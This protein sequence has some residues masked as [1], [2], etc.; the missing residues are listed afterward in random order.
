MRAFI[1]SLDAFVA[2]TLALVAIYSLIFFSSVP[3]AYYFLLTQGHYLSRDTLLSLSLTACTSDYGSCISPG[4]S[5]LDNIVA[6]AKP[7][8]VFNQKDLVKSTVGRMIPQQ[9]GYTLEISGNGGGSWDLVYDTSSSGDPQH[10]TGKNRRFTVASQIITFDYS[11]QVNKLK[12][13]P[14]VYASCQGNGQLEGGTLAG[15]A[16]GSGTNTAPSSG[17]ITCGEI[18][19]TNS[20]GTITNK[21]R[22]NINPKDIPKDNG[23]GDIVPS[24]EVNLVRL[25]V[26]I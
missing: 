20:D 24:T 8:W 23:G 2:F 5:I 18:P 13:S 22:G 7:P 10:V 26:Y 11:A 3:S 9:F 15:Q 14:Y 19:I 25:T 12:S 16:I 1:F 17:L 4:G 6:E 21:I